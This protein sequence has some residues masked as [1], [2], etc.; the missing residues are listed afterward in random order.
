MKS[1]LRGSADPDRDNS[2]FHVLP[3]LRT[4]ETRYLASRV[5]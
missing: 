4:A 2:Y 1:Y 3:E 5:G